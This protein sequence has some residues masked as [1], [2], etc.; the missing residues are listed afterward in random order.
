MISRI[1]TSALMRSSQRNLQANL[2]TLAK[3]Q[4]QATSQ[5]LITKPSDDPTGTSNAMAVRGEQRATAQYTRN[6]NNGNNWLTTI[7]SSLGSTL[8]LLNRV[9]DQTVL[10]AN[11]GAMSA[12]AKEAI[13]VELEG[14][15]DDLLK[16]ANTQYLGRNVF[17]GN[18]DAGAAFTDVAGVI[19]YTGTGTGVDRR[20]DANSTVRVDADGVAVFGTG[21]ASVF[22]LVDSIVA[23]LRAGVNVGPRLTELDTRIKSVISQQADVGARQGQIMK[24]QE[25]LVIKSAT[26]ETQRSV[27]EDI[28]LGKVILELKQAQVNYQAALQVTASVIQPTLM[29]F[30]S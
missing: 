18:S 25:N 24:A 6:A 2:S 27:I 3:L 20:V 23:D 1:T 19:A 21:P 22:T 10:G 17:A 12:A 13:A 29:D 26:L 15:R 11:D 16:V 14:L 4:D 5:K 28:D 7:D 9:R 30:L 8:T